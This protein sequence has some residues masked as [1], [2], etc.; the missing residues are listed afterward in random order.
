MHQAVHQQGEYRES[1]KLATLLAH[2]F[3]GWAL[4]AAT[5]ESR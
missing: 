4:C 5:M 2:A 1:E 3:I